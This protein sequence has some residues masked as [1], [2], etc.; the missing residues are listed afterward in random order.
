[1]HRCEHH[2]PAN[3]GWA[4]AIG[5]FLNLGFVVVEAFFGWWSQSL[6]LLADA[7]HNLGDVMGLILAWGGYALAKIQPSGRRTYGW[8]GSTILAALANGVLLLVA[9]GGIVWEAVGR[10][11]QP[12]Q[13]SA[14]TVIIVAGIG[15]VINTATALM[16][17]R[18]RK[19]D[20][21]IRG[22][23]LHMATD[24]LL[25]LGVVLAGLAIYWTGLSWIDPV[26]SLLI[27]VVI[28]LATTALLRESFDLAMQA[29]PENIN[30][31]EVED[32][33]ATLPGVTEVH[34]LHVWAVSTTEISMTAHL[35][36]PDVSNEDTL[37]REVADVLHDRFG[38]EHCTI[39]IERSVADTNCGQAVVGSL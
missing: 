15:V 28:L 33:L 37:L 16:F 3:Y 9:I 12:A 24:A 10:L 38:I 4:F 31:E 36:K 34:D 20:L 30:I 26:T 13:V 5:V 7:G 14:S 2:Q 39:Q 22:A 23:Y 1:M 35:V 11:T 8:R 17:L 25:S 32:Y 21:N 18:G 27:A 19:H 29:V 6:A